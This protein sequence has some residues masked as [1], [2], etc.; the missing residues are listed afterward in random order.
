MGSK[1]KEIRTE[2]IGKYQQLLNKRI[3]ELEKN[4]LQKDEINKDKHIK[5]LKAEIKRAKNAITFIDKREQTK[6]EA[7]KAKV[8]KANKPAAKKESKKKEPKKEKSKKSKKTDK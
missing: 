6:Q 4:G 5:H 3:G 7:N 1:H 8:D 2:Q